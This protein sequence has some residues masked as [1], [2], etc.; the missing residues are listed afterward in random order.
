VPCT[1][2]TRCR[3]STLRHW[4]RIFRSCNADRCER[5]RFNPHRT[6]K[7]RQIF[8]QWKGKAARAQ[9]QGT[10]SVFL[11]IPCGALSMKRHS[12]RRTLGPKLGARHKLKSSGWRN[13]SRDLAYRATWNHSQRKFSERC[14]AAPTGPRTV[15]K[16]QPFARHQGLPLKARVKIRPGG[17]ADR[18]VRRGRGYG[19][20]VYRH[21]RCRWSRANSDRRG[22]TFSFG[23]RHASCRGGR[24]HCR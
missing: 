2:D 19:R 21:F 5:P 7:N 18:C 16:R 10:A 4:R 8:P 24:L 9:P 6:S 3:W 22:P 20:R 14:D 1:S 12:G 11:T 17:E 15:A 13:L 23:L